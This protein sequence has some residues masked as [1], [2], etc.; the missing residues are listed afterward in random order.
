MDT[1]PLSAR[2]FK[3]HWRFRHCVRLNS[4]YRQ[5]LGPSSVFIYMRSPPVSAA[6]PDRDGD[7]A[8]AVARERSSLGNFIRRR[9]SQP[10]EAEDLLQDV[11]QELVEAYR[12]PEP[13][14]QVG[15]WLFRVARNRLID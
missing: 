14:E 8:A 9:I 11:L 13:I 6:V 2:D 3:E 4:A 12:L 10:E 7:L 5:Y 1:V 15:A